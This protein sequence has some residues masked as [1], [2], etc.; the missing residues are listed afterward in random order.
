MTVFGTRPEAIKM[1][2]VVFALRE[3][4]EFD[5][6]TVVTAQ[7]RGLLDDVLKVFDIVPDVDLDLMRPDQSLAQLTARVLTS[8]DET[9]EQLQPHLVLAQGDTTTV[10]ATAMACFYRGIPFG[11]VEA[12]LRTGNRR[13][14]FPEEVNRVV[15]G[16]VADLHFAPTATARD[17]LLREGVRDRDVLVTGNTVIDALLRVAELDVPLPVALAPHE[18]LVLLTAH[19][20]ES[21]GAPLREAFAAVRA[22]VERNDDVRVLYPVH[23]NPHVVSAAEEVLGGHPRVQLIPPLDYPTFVATMKRSTLVLTDS[24][25]VQ[26][27]APALAKPVLVLRDETE[28]PE[29]VEAGVVRLVGP[30]HAA[31][32]EW[33]Q[34]LLDDS[35]LYAQMATGA[36]PYGDGLAAGRIVERLSQFV[37]D[38]GVRRRA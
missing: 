24:G 12:G 32:E 4:P 8:M 35:A 2:P 29:A 34:R 13:M 3:A 10:M 31:I 18:R 22:I 37:H 19:R 20:R 9:F 23:P 7:H 25:G 5:P 26:E 38:R 30:H 1:A 21:F 36:S 14:P 11:H 16:V 28:R 15:A 27:E 17:N 6:V 33:T